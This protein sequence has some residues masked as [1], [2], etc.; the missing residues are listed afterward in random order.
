[1]FDVYLAGSMTGRKVKEVLEERRRAKN[2]LSA[3]G[4]SYYDPAENEGLENMDGESVIS[5]SFNKA[6]ML[7]YVKKDLA[8]VAD[9][10]CVLN[11][12]G[13]LASEGSCWEMA[14]A[15]FYRQIPVHIV[16]EMRISGEKMTFTNILVDGIHS[17]LTDA[18]I[19]VD[20]DLKRGQ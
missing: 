4:L 20:K 12:T 14:Y 7:V 1:M 3:N 18:V 5:N 8:M 19:A 9:S 17:S 15:T 10:R 2:L 11:I 16:A 6:R 13:D